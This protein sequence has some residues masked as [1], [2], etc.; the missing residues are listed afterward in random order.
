MRIMKVGNKNMVAHFYSIV[1]YYCYSFLSYEQM[2]RE[3][4]AFIT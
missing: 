3:S 2:M 1:G 4:I